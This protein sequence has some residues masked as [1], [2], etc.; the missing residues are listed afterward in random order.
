MTE[1]NAVHRRNIV[2]VGLFQGL[3]LLVAHELIRRSVWP[4]PPLMVFTPWYAIVIAVPLA[5]QLMIGSVMNRRLISFAVMVAAVLALLGTYVGWTVGVQ[6]YWSTVLW[7][8]GLT[9]YVA[10]HVLVPLAQ[11][12]LAQGR[13][14]FPY[15][16]LFEN[17]WNNTFTFIIA[18]VF[19]GIFWAL[20]ML[21]A[22]LFRV[23]KISFFF[24][25]FTS[26][27]FYYPALSAV[28]AFAVYLG[29]KHVSAV[30]TVRRIVLSIFRG[31]LPL[32]ALIAL[33]FLAA[34]PF[35]GLAPLWATGHAT[36]LM[37]TL[38]LLL[39]L[40]LNAV[41]QD[42][43]GEPPY[44]RALRRVIELAILLAPVYTLLC[45]YALSLRIDQHGWSVDRVWAVL[46]TGL[47][48]CYLVGYATA[49]VWRR[50]AWMGL[51]SPLNV[52]VAMVVI[53]VMVAV[54]TPLLDT[55]AITVRSQ[56]DRLLVGKVSADAFDYRYF[57]FH[58]A[59][60]G[61]DALRQLEQLT[62]HP[63]AETIRGHAQRML[64]T[65]YP[66]G[67][68][69][70]LKPVVEKPDDLKRHLVLYPQNTEFDPTFLRHLF[71]VR[72]QPLMKDCINK[73]PCSVLAVDLND[74]KQRDY[75]V[76]SCPTHWEFKAEVFARTAG[77]WS[78]VGD[79]NSPNSSCPEVLRESENFLREGDF[80]AA[81][82]AWRNLRVG[83]TM[84]PFTEK[85]SLK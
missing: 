22:S 28:S 67:E 51:M 2:L 29:R 58:L 66:Y 40:F 20:L 77:G 50:K 43:T 17:A 83:K 8:F 69:E 32:L 3:L 57:R 81:R 68:P 49:V 45:F 79:L 14:H 46:I 48:G 4:T 30:V 61:N 7:S 54:N 65:T 41:Y 27:Y 5:L 11:T 72:A 21:W 47:A 52:G 6:D 82:S 36:S 23:L 38:Q 85:E 31:L 55:R 71:D 19:T 37:L 70:G 62:D 76:I 80:G 12:G 60:V 10:W 63:E 18:W 34:L 33:L 42:G 25:V 75:V 84:V 9:I 78:H 39:I 53:A 74:D 73:K 44:H 56:L 59:R 35:T 15:V 13:W 64:A 26:P 16:S 24:D 1:L